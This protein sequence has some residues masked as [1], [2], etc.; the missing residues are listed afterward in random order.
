MKSVGF[1]GMVAGIMGMLPSASGA[2]SIDIYVDGGACVA[3]DV[4]LGDQQTVSTD[5]SP[6]EALGFS[7]S[8]AGAYGSSSGQVSGRVDAVTGELALYMAGSRS[9][10][11]GAAPQAAATVLLDLYDV[12]R[13]TGT[14]Y[15]DILMEYEASWAARDSFNYLVNTVISPFGPA[16]V[17]T[18]ISDD[19][20]SFMIYESVIGSPPVA[21]VSGLI[22]TR[23][24]FTDAVDLDVLVAWQ[25][26]GVGF[27]DGPFNS[28]LLDS[29]NTG[30]AAVQ[31]SQGLTVTYSDPDFLSNATF[32]QVS[33]VPLPAAG[34]VLLSGL[35]A[36]GLMRRRSLRAA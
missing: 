2:A 1:A 31:A 23:A 29:N 6:R 25:M 14:G 4:C 36:L 28:F 24:Y 30:R 5:S 11:A 10:E 18:Q 9:G 34:W 7:W 33:A 12:I 27:A 26:Q 15:I 13:V 3:F 21:A 20:P 8:G 17:S 32:G 35:G 19:I 22:G 16:G